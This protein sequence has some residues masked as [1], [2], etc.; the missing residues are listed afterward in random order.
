VHEVWLVDVDER[1][2]MALRA[3]GGFDEW[4][5]GDEV[6]SSLLP[7]FSAPVTEV[8]APTTIGPNR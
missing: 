5:D 8:L 6:A 7:G 4:V 3:D 1:V 2:V